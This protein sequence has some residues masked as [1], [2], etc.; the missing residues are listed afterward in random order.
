MK[1][2]RLV[3]SMIL[4]TAVSANAGAVREKAAL[5]E[6]AALRYW[7]AFAQMQDST[8]A[9]AQVTELNA[10]LDG[11]AA[12]DDAKYKDLVEMNEHALATM[13]RGT[14]LA[15][16][17]WGLDY[18][19][20]S[21]TPVDYV[22]KAAA[23]ARLNVLYIFHLRV[24]GEKDEEMRALAAGIRFSQDIANGGSLFATLVAKDSLVRHLRAVVFAMQG[25][26]L[27][28]PQR[29]ILQQ[30][31]LRLGADPLNWRAA[32]KAEMRVFSDFQWTTAVP[33][34]QI[35]QA[36]LVA[37]DDPS[38]LPELQELITSLTPQIQALIPNPKRVLE[39][40]RDFS[41]K[42]QETRSKLK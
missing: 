35:S 37:I 7:S 31:V 13:A 21:E 24:T 8:I 19:L 5:G 39:E 27:S 20:G 6:N 40:K 3:L 29:T 12:Y 10:M 18:A 33:Y 9:R 34:A 14:A 1:I 16:C 17:D 36:Y 15:N 38:A 28:A 32:V 30:A 25:Q 41:N 11:T 4:A 22:E 2:T 42:L 26:E 23:L